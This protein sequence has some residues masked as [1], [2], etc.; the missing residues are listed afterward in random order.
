MAFPDHLLPSSWL[1]PS[2]LIVIMLLGT[3]VYT[4]PWRQL[5]ERQLGNVLL[6]ACVVLLI[7]WRMRA[8][9]AGGLGLHFLGL[10]TL[11]LMLGWQ[12]ALLGAALVVTLL[13]LAGLGGWQVYALNILID[14]AIPVLFSFAFFRIIDRYLPN[15]FFIY[16]FVSVF[17][18]S[19]L[20]MSVRLLSLSGLA[21]AS[22]NVATAELSDALL[23][24][25][26]LL[27]LPEGLLNGMALTI[28]VVYRPDWVMTFDDA[29]YLDNK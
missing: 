13:S 25:L 22:G 16:I 15:H 19:I 18:G 2:L 17:L 12:F 23:P 11:T 14:G 28:F 3:A 10:T 26:L 7:L 5:R 6:V 20:T 9:F 29:R 1:L 4:A 8:G 24:S 21:L 27:G